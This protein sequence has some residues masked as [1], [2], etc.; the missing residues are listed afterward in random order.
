MSLDLETKLYYKQYDIDY[1]VKGNGTAVHEADRLKL[2]L[3][4]NLARR[5]EELT[6]ID[7]EIERQAQDKHRGRPR[8]QK[9]V[10]LES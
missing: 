1:K 5:A 8:K 4:F 9:E 3:Y 6:T 10:K 2:N 7:F